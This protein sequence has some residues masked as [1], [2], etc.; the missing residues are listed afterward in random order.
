MRALRNTMLGRTGKNACLGAPG[1]FTLLEL[2]IVM[3]ISGFLL[4]G[5][6]TMYKSVTDQI[7]WR[8]L[9]TTMSN[10]S[11]AITN[12]ANAMRRYPCPANP[13]LSLG[14]PNYGVEDCASATLVAGQRTTTATGYPNKDKVLIG[15]FPIYMDTGASLAP[16]GTKVPISEFLNSSSSIQTNFADPWNNRLVYAVSY[17]QSAAPKVNST[18]YPFNNDFGT[19]AVVD[20]NDHPT[21]GINNDAHYVIVSEGPDGTH[22]WPCGIATR[23]IEYEN[24]D[25]DSIFRSSIL[26]Q[27]VLKSGGV[28]VAN[29]GATKNMYY[30]DRIISYTLTRTD[31]WVPNST[32]NVATR[33]EIAGNAGVGPNIKKPA[34]KLDV[35]GSIVADQNARANMLCKQNGTTRTADTTTCLNPTQVYNIQCATGYA[36]MVTL[37]PTT[38]A[39]STT[40]AVPSFVP[41]DTSCPTA[42]APSAKYIKSIFSDGTVECT[43]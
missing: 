22:K 18:S 37:N 34:Q 30:D 20:E 35:D 24:C 29:I 15:Y 9:S 43:E 38:H 1:G 19:I 32:T 39:L 25:N 17:N 5:F 26:R 42:A 10:A 33:K 41:A 40:C 16:S 11:N 36:T 28:E 12:A 27:G 8:R 21:N 2:A 7:R 14:D 6:L 4:V 31:I 13:A 23:P 3:V